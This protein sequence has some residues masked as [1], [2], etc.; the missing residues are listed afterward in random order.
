MPL[1]VGNIL[2]TALAFAWHLYNF[3]VSFFFKIRFERVEYAYIA[4]FCI[5]GNSPWGSRS[6][7]EAKCAF[8]FFAYF[9][10]R[11]TSN[12]RCLFYEF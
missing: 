3:F 10:H 9:L 1:R 11:S 5:F 4:V 6:R 12:P 7:L 2:D 8:T